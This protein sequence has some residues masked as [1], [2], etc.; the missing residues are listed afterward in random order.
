MVSGHNQRR[1]MRVPRHDAIWTCQ[2]ASR[3]PAA[4][5]PPQTAMLHRSDAAS[6]VWRA[7]TLAWTTPSPQYPALADARVTAG[8]APPGCRGPHDRFHPPAAPRRVTVWFAIAIA[9]RLAEPAITFV[10]NHSCDSGSRWRLL[11]GA[12][13]SVGG[14]RRG[15]SFGDLRARGGSGSTPAAAARC[16]RRSVQ[17]TECADRLLVRRSPSVNGGLAASAVASVRSPPTGRPRSCR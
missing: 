1:K 17:P 11:P 14:R 13:R 2:Q 12:G 10:A 9:R 8:M 4:G 6:K 5:C 7:S 3:R 16:R 15:A